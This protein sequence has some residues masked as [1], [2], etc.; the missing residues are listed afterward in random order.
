M[1]HK[2][3]RHEIHEIELD[4]VVTPMLDMAF[5]LLVFFIITYHPSAMEMQID[6]TL[7][8]PKQTISGAPPPPDKPK[9]ANPD[10]PPKLEETLTV[11]VDALTAKDPVDLK[12]LGAPKSIELMKPESIGKRDVIFTNKNGE[13]LEKGLADLEKALKKILADNPASSE[14]EINIKGDGELGWEYLMRVQDVCRI[15]Y[16]VRAS[17]GKDTLFKIKTKR[18]EGDYTKRVGFKNVGYVPPDEPKK[19]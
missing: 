19:P 9:P 11:F 3:K 6:G 5:Q 10:D 18:E 12:Y 14:T 8:P 13:D 16:G 4:K 7:L 17:G 2:R 15:K 1:S